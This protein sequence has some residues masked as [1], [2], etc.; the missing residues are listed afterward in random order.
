MAAIPQTPEQLDALVE[1][2]ITDEL[3]KQNTAERVRE[4]LLAQNASMQ[5]RLTDPAATNPDYA[6]LLA[7]LNVLEGKPAYVHTFRFRTQAEAVG[8]DGGETLDQLKYSTLY[9]YAHVLVE[10]WREDPTDTTE[11]PHG[12]ELIAVYDP[13]APAE[14]MGWRTSGGAAANAGQIGLKLVKVTDPAATGVL[15]YDPNQPVAATQLRYYDAQDGQGALFYQAQQDLAVPVPAPVPGQTNANWAPAARPPVPGTSPTGVTII[16]TDIPGATS[17]LTNALVVEAAWTTIDGDWNQTG[18]DKRV[19]VWGLSPTAFSPI[20]YLRDAQGV[21]TEV[22]VDVASATA[23]P[24]AKTELEGNYTIKPSDTFPLNITVPG[25]LVFGI[26]GVVGPRGALNPLA[27]EV[28]D[29]NNPGGYSVAPNTLTLLPA[30]MLQPGEL[31]SWR[32]LA[33]QAGVSK[34]YVDAADSALQATQAQQA[35]LIAAKAD[36]VNGKVPP[37]QLPGYLDDIIDTF[38]LANL[39][40]P[41]ET[42]KIYIDP[43]T[44][45][46]YRWTGSVYI[47]LAKGADIPPVTLTAGGNTTTY[48][49]LQALL[50]SGV[51]YSYGTINIQRPIPRGVGSFSSVAYLNGFGNTVGGTDATHLLEMSVSQTRETAFSYARI[52]TDTAILCRFEDSILSGRMV[53]CV[54]RGSNNKIPAALSLEGGTFTE[55]DFFNSFTLNADGT[56][57]TPDGGTVTDKRSGAGAVTKAYID[58]ADATNASNIGVL[59]NLATTAKSNLVAAINEVAARATAPDTLTAITYAPSVALDFTASSV[60]SLALSGNVTF[61]TSNKALGK[62]KR[63]FLSNTSAS[64]VTLTFPSA[65]GFLGT[66]PTSLAAG[67]KAVLSVECAT[68]STESDIYAG[69]AAQS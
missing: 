34:S 27:L 15:P 37:S 65:W 30:A 9:T 17:K 23:V 36:L 25:A 69:Y 63:V 31:V 10:F 45:K 16:R 33:G 51:S 44:N 19:V 49:S 18:P 1:L 2:N 7:R 8:H 48:V 54:L 28:G 6:A 4:V 22:E 24:R 60:Q 55:S 62:A 47:E 50:A 13:D 20:G 29:P 67:K 66:I 56:Y 42:G 38:N 40:Q 12:Q 59:A 26:V 41:G 58:A 39:P 21:W 53:N 3:L 64:S 52:V 61:T 46:E 32:Y 11:I 35:M 43:D 14:R 68:G 57:T 5:N